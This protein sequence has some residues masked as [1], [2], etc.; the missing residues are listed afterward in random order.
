MLSYTRARA[1]VEGG[2][3]KEEIMP[4]MIQG[5]KVDTEIDVFFSVVCS[6]VSV[7]VVGRVW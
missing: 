5:R 7:C 3:F 6:G 4:V 1:S 2:K